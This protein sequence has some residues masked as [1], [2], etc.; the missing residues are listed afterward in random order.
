[1]RT[2]R[3]T[4]RVGSK[5]VKM[6]HD[7]LNY[8]NQYSQEIAPSTKNI[9]KASWLDTCLGPMVAIADEKVLYLLE[10]VDKKALKRE[11]DRLC[12]RTKS[13]IIPGTTEPIRSIENELQQYFSGTLV[14][15]KTAI[16]SLGSA[17][18][19]NVWDELKKIPYGTTR[20]YLDIAKE[21]GRPT[22]FRAVANAN[23]ANQL[24]II[25]PCHRVI[26]SNG[27][28]GGYGGGVSRK[29]WLLHH[30]RKFRS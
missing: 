5:V 12:Q 17:F 2:H 18:Q 19:K 3:S 16:V 23:G 25:I 15:F 21:I 8:F 30:E 11:V 20:S 10:F 7:L 27:E 24:S 22:S 13:A 4:K 9:L 26:N 28:L 14:Q 29:E 1:M 6:T